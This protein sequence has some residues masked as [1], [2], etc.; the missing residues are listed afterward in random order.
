MK[1][2]KI[3]AGPWRSCRRLRTKQ[4]P[5]QLYKTR[6]LTAVCHTELDYGVPVAGYGTSRMQPK[7]KK[8]RKF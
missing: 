1:R 2:P 4:S 7:K 8:A 3:E 6:V 5:S